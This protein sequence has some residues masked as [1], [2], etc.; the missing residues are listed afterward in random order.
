VAIL[1]E[2]ELN[3]MASDQFIEWL[4]RKLTE[5]GIKK[6]IPDDDVLAQHIACN[7][8]ATDRDR[9]NKL[10]ANSEALNRGA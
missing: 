1:L 5:H 10:R 9:S 4:E 6:V 2:G 8:P 3:A 7:L